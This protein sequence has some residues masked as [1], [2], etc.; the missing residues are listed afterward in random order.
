MDRVALPTRQPEVPH[1]LQ[2]WTHAN[3]VSDPVRPQSEAWG[4]SPSTHG[5]NL[6]PVPLRG[7]EKGE[8]M[9][10]ELCN[11]PNCGV[12]VRQDVSAWDDEYARLVTYVGD[13]V[14]LTAVP[15][16]LA[17]ALGPFTLLSPGRVPAAPPLL[18]DVAS[19]GLPPA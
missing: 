15:P 11:E 17:P 4:R 19:G 16:Q 2:M 9:N 7:L 10:D 12:C 3:Q 1:V 13:Y 8:I 6:S 5:R 14:V 18:R